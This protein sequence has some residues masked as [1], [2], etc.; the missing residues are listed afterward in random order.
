VTGLEPAINFPNAKSFEKG[1]GRVAVLAPGESRA[2]QVALE[3]HGDAASL[4]AAVQSVEALQAG[5]TPEICSEP[6]PAWA[7]VG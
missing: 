2:Y 4:K 1:K 5:V 3:V 7:P 6:D